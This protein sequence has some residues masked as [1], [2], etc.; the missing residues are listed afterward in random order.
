[1]S[2]RKVEPELPA[3]SPCPSALGSRG[4]A[5]LPRSAAGLLNAANLSLA[6][7]CDGN[8]KFR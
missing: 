2:D 5:D 7:E 4:E 1:M 3:L 8:V 6:D